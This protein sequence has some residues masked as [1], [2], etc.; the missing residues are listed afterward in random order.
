MR[1]RAS[2]K[3]SSEGATY[4]VLDDES[5]QSLYIEPPKEPRNMPRKKPLTKAEKRDRRR[6]R[7]A[8]SDNAFVTETARVFTSAFETAEDASTECDRRYLDVDLDL[9]Y[10]RVAHEIWRDR[11]EI[12]PALATAMADLIAENERHRLAM[13]DLY[14]RFEALAVDPALRVNLDRPEDYFD[15]VRTRLWDTPSRP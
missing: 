7:N 11:K 12:G 2:R 5:V 14:R 1:H 15:I 4:S 8:E 13:I 3:A 10:R 9:Q 6:Q